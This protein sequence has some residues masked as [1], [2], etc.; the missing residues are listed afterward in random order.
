MTSMVSN[1]S[2]QAGFAIFWKAKTPI[3]LRDEGGEFMSV[4]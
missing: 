3:G 2:V 4:L 1:P